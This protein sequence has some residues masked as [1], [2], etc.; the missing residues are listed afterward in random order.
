MPTMIQ[1]ASRQPPDAAHRARSCSAA[2]ASAT[3][4]LAAST[5]MS[6]RASQRTGVSFQR[7]SIPTAAT[8]MSIAISGTNMALK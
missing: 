8:A 7:V 3:S 5:G 6:M 1:A 2:A 4:R